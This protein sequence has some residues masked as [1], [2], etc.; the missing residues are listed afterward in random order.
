MPSALLLWGRN[1]NASDIINQRAIDIN[2]LFLSVDRFS[3][4]QASYENILTYARQ[5]PLLKDKT[6]SKITYRGLSAE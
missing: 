3:L 5:H 6:S 4:G 2:T 1:E